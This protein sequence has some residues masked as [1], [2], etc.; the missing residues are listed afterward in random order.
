MHI[1]VKKL[2]K[3]YDIVA[4]TRKDTLYSTIDFCNNF[5][6]LTL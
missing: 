4:Q 2:T 3:R 5:M 6:I 1:V